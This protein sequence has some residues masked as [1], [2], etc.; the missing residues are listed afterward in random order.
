MRARNLFSN[1]GKNEMFL[2]L[3]LCLMTGGVT[4]YKVFALGYSFT[5]IGSE[6]GYSIRLVMDVKNS[7]GDCEVKLTLPVQSERQSILHEKQVSGPFRYTISQGR[8]GRWSAKNF[9]GSAAITYSFLAQTAAKTYPMP[10]GAD[11]PTSVTQILRDNLQPT[12]R[13]QSEAPEIH[14]K[15]WALAPAGID[16]TGAMKTLYNFCYTQV[17]YEEIKGPTDALTALKLGSA[18]CNGKNRLFVALLRARGIPARIANGLILRDSRKRTTHAWTEAWIDNQWVPFCPTN[19]HFASIPETYLE[20][21]KGDLA[22]ITHSKHIGF[23]WRWYVRHQ[24]RQSQKAILSNA[25]NPMNIFRAW[26]TLKEY[27]ITLNMVIVILMVPIGATLVALARNV[28]GVVPFGTFM[29]TLIAVSFRDTGFF[30]GGAMFLTIILTGLLM[31]L[32][33][34]RLRLLHI[35]RLVIM[36]TFV[37]AAI[38]GVSLALIKL[39]VASG[40]GVS[41]FPMAI[42]SLTCERFTITLIQEGWR[43]AVRRM[44]ETFLVAAA[45]FWVMNWGPLEV[46]I[47]AFPELLLLNVALNLVIG[48]WT[49]MR[50]TEYWRFHDVL[51]APEGIAP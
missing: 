30:L 5:G 26:M 29:P 21:A 19:G 46:M 18:S 51:A 31:N 17:H 42:V 34:M 37:V 27:Q 38:L 14:D 7:G 11:I 28:V 4:A 3:A 44:I 39:G 8:V 20:L 47:V 40:A 48:S 41:L 15:A 24:M 16:L 2:A 10:E 25:D 35:P 12:E 49:G 13:I 22:V 1:F 50:L 9:S 43:D 33:L 23:D 36:I 45:C 6:D 32:I